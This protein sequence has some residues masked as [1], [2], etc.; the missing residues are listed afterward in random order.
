MWP[1]E[2]H[3]HCGQ[4]VQCT[5]CWQ[6]RSRRDTVGTFTV[7]SGNGAAGKS[8]GNLQ[9]ICRKSLPH[10]SY[11]VYYEILER[12]AGTKAI[13]GMLLHRSTR[14]F[15]ILVFLSNQLTK[16]TC[17]VAGR[18]IRPDTKVNCSR[19]CLGAWR[20]RECDFFFC[21][22][23]LDIVSNWIKLTS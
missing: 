15:L 1:A 9:E 11:T 8:A 18:I 2:G 6:V 22:S 14:T 20:G 19:I 4:Y 3:L 5:S 23:L 17:P 16:P 21:K 13:E 12:C 10:N 7:L